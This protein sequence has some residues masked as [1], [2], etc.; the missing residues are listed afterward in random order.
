MLKKLM[1]RII[2]GAEYISLNK[3]TVSKDALI[4]NHH[5]LQKAHPTSGICPVL[6]S[7]AYGHGLQ[8][9]A[10]IFDAMNCPFLIVDSL[11][12][13]YELSKLHVKT[14]IL[15]LGYTDPRNF[16][17]KQLPF[18]VA[19]FDLKTAAALNITQRNCQV[20]LFIDTGMNREGIRVEELPQF[21]KTF[22][23][24]KNLRVTGLCSHF[25]DADNNESQQFTHTQVEQFKKAHAIVTQYGYYPVYRHISASAGAFAVNDPIFNMIRGGLA[26][27]GISPFNTAAKKNSFITLAPA[28]QFSSTLVQIKKIKKGE[29]IGYNCTFTAKKDMTIGLL[30][31]GYY[32]GVDRRL[33]NRGTVTIQGVACP[34]VGRVSMN[35][36]TVDISNV[37]SPRIGEDVII[38]SR[39]HSDINSLS[40]AAVQSETIPYD[41][42]VHLAHTTKRE[43]V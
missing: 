3:I 1:G 2:R 6:K 27:Y 9:V 8:Q 38:F 7:N 12:E 36:T 14:P 21:L 28:L 11:F 40:N 26:H 34:I 41:L 33:S 39:E 17:V 20:H 13:A 42:L 23:S 24:F 4:F 31:A 19:V 15:I 32:E 29:I 5:S 37:P 35:M 18:H 10:P 30:P 22:S 16:S 25:A 43:I